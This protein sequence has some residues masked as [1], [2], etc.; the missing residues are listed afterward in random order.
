MTVRR[1]LAA[2]SRADGEL[3]I[4]PMM[5]LFVALIPM[6]LLSAVFLEVTVIRMNLPSDSSAAQAPSER[7][8]LTVSIEEDRWVLESSKTERQTLDRSQPG[9]EQ[10]LRTA[11]TSLKERFPQNNEIVIRSEART[12]YADIVAVMD[13]S[14][15]T[16][17]PEVGLA[18]L[19]R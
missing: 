15:E 6:L 2:L 7:L 16:G 18:A 17:T 5:N 3:E 10:E 12:R 9:S 13:I 4:L 8:A 1:R 19:Q 11:L 14:R